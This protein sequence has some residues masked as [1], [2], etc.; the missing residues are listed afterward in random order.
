MDQDALRGPMIKKV[1]LTERTFLSDE[2]FAFR[3][4]GGFSSSSFSISLS[5]SIILMSLLILSL[6]LRN[7]PAHVITLP[8]LPESGWVTH[9]REIGIYFL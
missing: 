6:N 4:F 3:T 1:T 5:S 2:Y 9:V 7:L 8:P